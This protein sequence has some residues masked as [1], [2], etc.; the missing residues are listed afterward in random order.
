[1]WQYNFLG[2]SSFCDPLEPDDD[3]RLPTLGYAPD[4]ANKRKSFSA[5]LAAIPAHS[6]LAI[7]PKRK[8]CGTVFF[9]CEVARLNIFPRNAAVQEFGVTKGMATEGFHLKTFGR[10]LLRGGHDLKRMCAQIDALQTGAV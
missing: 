9:V 7:A 5:A 3:T 1:L 2:T 8:C 6:P 10:G 4:G